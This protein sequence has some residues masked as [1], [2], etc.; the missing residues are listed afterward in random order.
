HESQHHESGHHERF[1]SGRGLSDHEQWEHDVVVYGEGC[2]ERDGAG[3]DRPAVDHQQAL[4]DTGGEPMHAGRANTLEH[5]SEYRESEV[6]HSSRSEHYESRHY[7][8]NAE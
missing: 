4:S 7:K 1:D 3:R 5:R 2:H 6:V 8:W